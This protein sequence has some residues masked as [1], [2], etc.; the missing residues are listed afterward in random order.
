MLRESSGVQAAV[1]TLHGEGDAKR[2]VGYVVGDRDQF[3]EAA[4]RAVLESRL[5][6]YMV[7]SV[8][9][10]LERLPLMQNGKLDRAV[11]PE[12]GDRKTAERTAPSTPLETQLLG[13][14]HE[15]LARDDLG[16]TD[17]FFEAGGH[18]LLALKVLAKGAQ[19][20]LASLTL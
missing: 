3:E 12:P 6:G 9:V 7:P 17:N 14:W 16:V 4:V 10:W 20:G 18:S 13:I 15:V 11:L 19:A 5:P 2:I 1:A 8:L